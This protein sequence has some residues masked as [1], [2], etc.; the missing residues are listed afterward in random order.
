MIKLTIGFLLL[1]AL[2]YSQSITG[3]WKTLDDKTGEVKSIVEI[4]EKG[5]KFYGKIIKIFRKAGEEQDPVCDDCP[6][7]DARYNKK[8]IGL[9]IIRDMKKSGDEYTEG[10]ILDPENG[11]IYRCKL[12]IEGNDLMVRGYWGPFF[13][14][15]TWKKVQ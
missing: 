2:L 7:D 6:K 12:W 1:P 8:I 9:E 3:R 15:Q 11:K 13:R 14:T 5:G 4:T 10:N